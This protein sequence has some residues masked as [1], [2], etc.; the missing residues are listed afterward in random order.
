M[1]ARVIGPFH[2]WAVPCSEALGFR[3]HPQGLRFVCFQRS[4]A[5]CCQ[6]WLAGPV[7]LRH[8]K[9]SRF[10]WRFRPL[11]LAGTCGGTSVGCANFRLLRAPGDCMTRKHC[12]PACYPHSLHFFRFAGQ[13]THHHRAM[14]AYAA[15]PPA[16]GPVVWTGAISNDDRNM[17]LYGKDACVQGGT[18][19]LTFLTVWMIMLYNGFPGAAR[20]QDNLCQDYPWCV[21]TLEGRI[22][23]SYTTYEQCRAT[24]SG[25]G[26]CFRNKRTLWCG[27]GASPSPSSTRRQTRRRHP[28][29]PG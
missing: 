27:D 12:G 7:P 13:R 3:S 24:A 4:K 10:S 18:M 25:I 21:A 19:R 16:P 23:C 1:L 15:A 20:A 9:P 29:Q 26:G 17:Y 2:I 28:P 11:L 5:P 6:L 14:S 22:D 8:C